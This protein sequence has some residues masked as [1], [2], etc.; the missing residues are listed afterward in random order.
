[1]NLPL[2]AS[3]A[4]ITS[5]QACKDARCWRFSANVEYIPGKNDALQ[6]GKV[7]YFNGKQGNRLEGKLSSEAVPSEVVTEVYDE[8]YRPLFQRVVKAKGKSVHFSLPFHEVGKGKRCVF[9]YFRQGGP[10]TRLEGTL[11]Y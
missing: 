3:A 11:W 2:S 9:I 6:Q 1:M 10:N 4:Y 5:E 8:K 7:F